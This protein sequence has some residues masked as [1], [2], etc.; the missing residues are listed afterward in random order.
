LLVLR[1]SPPSFGGRKPTKA[2]IREWFESAT[3]RWTDGEHDEEYAET[4]G[5]FTD[6]VGSALRRTAEMVESG[7]GVVFS[8]GGPVSWATAS[9]LAEDREIAGRL[10]GGPTR[11][12]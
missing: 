3:D 4:F 10:C 7:T 12:A 2:E 1:K 9:L 6:R 5:A 8:S 11:S